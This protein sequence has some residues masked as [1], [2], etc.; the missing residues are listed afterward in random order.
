V[1]A[2]LRMQVSE[3]GVELTDVYKSQVQV[4]HYDC[5]DYSEQYDIA[6]VVRGVLT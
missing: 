5:D 2:G 4:E 1:L 3:L 6:P